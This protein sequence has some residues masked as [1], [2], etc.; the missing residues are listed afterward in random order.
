MGVYDQKARLNKLG[1]LI[2]ACCCTCVKKRRTLNNNYLILSF[3]ITMRSLLCACVRV[4]VCVYALAVS[5][6]DI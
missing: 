5:L 6:P 2:T 3:S 1:S 4:S